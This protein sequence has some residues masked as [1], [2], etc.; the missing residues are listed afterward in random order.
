M[1]VE[2]G[3]FPLFTAYRIFLCYDT[4]IFT[5]QTTEGSVNNPGIGSASE[6]MVCGKIRL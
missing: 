1:C 4:V 3:Y 2:G 5:T 6:G